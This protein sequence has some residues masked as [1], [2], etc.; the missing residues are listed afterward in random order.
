MI[1]SAYQMISTNKSILKNIQDNYRHIVIDEFQDIN[2]IQLEIIIELN[3]F[4]DYL[5]LVGDDLQNIY[6]SNLQ[7][8]GPQNFH[9]PSHDTNDN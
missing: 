6:S 5:F 1:L 7:L 2:E 3:K 4:C 9:G 8:F